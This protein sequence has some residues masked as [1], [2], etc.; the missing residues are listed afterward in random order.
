MPLNKDGSV[1]YCLDCI[2]KMAIH[3]A[4]CG[5]PIFIAD[6]VTLYTPNDKNFRIPDQAVVH[7]RDP[8]QLVG[9]L[10]WNCAMSGADRAGFWVPGDN[11]KGKVHRV[12]SPL[13]IALGT[14][15]EVIVS[16]VTDMAEAH[17]LASGG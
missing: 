13:E 14:G 4:W 9:C 11:G 2:G 17:R 7:S 15:K 12:P 5:N 6:A 3:C 1:D 10:G 8:L 16:D